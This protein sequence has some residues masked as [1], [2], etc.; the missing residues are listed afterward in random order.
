M[1]WLRESDNRAP[2]GSPWASAVSLPFE[3]LV[4]GDELHV[5]HHRN[6][7]SCL[8]LASTAECGEINL[9][10]PIFFTASGHI[11][12][13]TIRVAS[14]TPTWS[15][16]LADHN[17]WVEGAGG[18]RLL[19]MPAT[20]E[21]AESELSVSIDADIVEVAWSACAGVG[22]IRVPIDGDRV[23]HWSVPGGAESAVH[24]GQ[25][26]EMNADVH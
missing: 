25:T 10:S 12:G 17:L 23:L 9:V 26:V 21:V 8:P 7:A 5:R 15:L 24:A 13:S 19:E 4:E 1:S 11:A 14:S 3:L 16:H 22:S 6:L 20:R 18:E 2:Q